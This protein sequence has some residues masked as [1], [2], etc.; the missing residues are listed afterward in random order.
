M[1]RKAFTSSWA[2]V[3]HAVRSGEPASPTT[4]SRLPRNFNSRMATPVAFSTQVL[5]GERKK[6]VAQ[7]PQRAPVYPTTQLQN[8]WPSLAKSH[9]PCPS[10]HCRKQR[11]EGEREG[12]TD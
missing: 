10:T 6:P 1:R 4:L 12:D 2:P 3:T 5:V 8:C 9:C 7:P 11:R